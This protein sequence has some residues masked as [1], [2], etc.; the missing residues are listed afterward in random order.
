MDFEQRIRS[1]GLMYLM[2]KLESTSTNGEQ[3]TALKIDVMPSNT[4]G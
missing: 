2:L 1:D 4:T 3:A